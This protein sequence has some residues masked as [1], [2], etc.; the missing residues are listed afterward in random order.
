MGIAALMN[1]KLEWKRRVVHWDLCVHEKKF[2]HSIQRHQI[3]CRYGLLQLTTVNMFLLPSFSL[4]LNWNDMSYTSS[5]HCLPGRIYNIPHSLTVD[6]NRNT[7]V[8]EESNVY[9]PKLKRPR[10][11]DGNC[12]SLPSKLELT[13]RVTFDSL[14]G[15][16]SIEPKKRFKSMRCE[17]KWL[18]VAGVASWSPERSTGPSMFVVGACSMVRKILLNT[19]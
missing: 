9:A 7:F 1:S 15:Y 17:P 13:L 2:S 18:Y 19:I 6:H 12:T 16:F 8:W 4:L 11:W 3:R 5:A 14:W 10:R